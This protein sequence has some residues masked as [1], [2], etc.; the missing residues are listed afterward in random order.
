MDGRRANAGG[1]CRSESGMHLWIDEDG[2]P[3]LAVPTVVGIHV[4]TCLACGCTRHT[5]VRPDGSRGRSYK[6]A[7]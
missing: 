5:I 7:R 4:H 6:D 3:T 1:S 2:R